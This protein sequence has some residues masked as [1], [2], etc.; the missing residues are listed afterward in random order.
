MRGLV[1]QVQYRFERS[2]RNPMG[3]LATHVNYGA[4]GV[5]V[6]PGG[7]DFAGREISKGAAPIVVIGRQIWPQ[8]NEALPLFMDLAIGVALP[9]SPATGLPGVTPYVRGYLGFGW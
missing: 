6:T 5:L 1:P 2:R 3:G 4:M 9:Q 7:F 8:K